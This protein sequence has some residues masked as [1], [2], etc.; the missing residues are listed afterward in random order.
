[1]MIF[2]S[3]LKAHG[4]GRNHALSGDLVVN[5]LPSLSILVNMRSYRNDGNYYVDNG[6]G[7][8]T[9]VRTIKDVKEA[10]V[11]RS[12]LQMVSIKA[13]EYL[14]SGWMEWS[15]LD[16]PVLQPKPVSLSGGWM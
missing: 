4:K 16:R 9:L 15:T 14:P 10:E 2:Y 3:S 12:K 7:L 13:K 5:K 6:E 1:M 8:K 11:F